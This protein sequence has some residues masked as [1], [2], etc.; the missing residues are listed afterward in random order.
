MRFVFKDKDYAAGL[1]NM[2]RAGQVYSRLSKPTKAALQERIA[3][4]HNGI[5]AI[6]S[7]SGQAAIHL[8][9]Q[10]GQC[11]RTYHCLP[12]HRWSTHNLLAHALRRFGIETIFADPRSAEAF[13]QQ[14]KTL[15]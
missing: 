9:S 10:Y 1:F 15:R 8:Q 12:R 5:G 6:A 11:R 14:E 2:E 7:A 4:L 13:K 3:I